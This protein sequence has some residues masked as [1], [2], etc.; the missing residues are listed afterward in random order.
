LAVG[1][2]FEPELVARRGLHLAEQLERDRE[3]IAQ[4]ADARPDV[5]VL[6]LRGEK[7]ERRE[8]AGMA[9]YQHARDP[10]LPGQGEGVHGPGA[11]EGDQREV[12]RIV[13]ALDRDL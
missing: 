6:D 7:P 4:R 10:D 12:A 3:A 8:V 11:P 13:P 5:V 2:A 1:E 9:G